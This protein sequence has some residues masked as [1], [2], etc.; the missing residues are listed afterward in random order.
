MRSERQEFSAE[1]NCARGRGLRFPLCEGFPRPSAAGFPE[2]LRA[3]FAASFYE[4]SFRGSFSFWVELRFESAL[5]PYRFCSDE[6][7]DVFE[8]VSGV[9]TLIC[10]KLN[11]IADFVQRLHLSETIYVRYGSGFGGD[12]YYD[13]G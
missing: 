11:A 12:I 1:T 2:N 10:L 4:W 3:H 6:K 5:L 13:C 8:K 7:V 9:G